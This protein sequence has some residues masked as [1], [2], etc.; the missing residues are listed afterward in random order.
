MVPIMASRSNNQLC[1]AHY[2]L[3]RAQAFR[4]P[5]EPFIFA[6]DFNSRPHGAAHSYLTTGHI[7]AKQVAPWYCSDRLEEPVVDDLVGGLGNLTIERQPT[8]QKVRYLLDATLN[9]FCRWLRILGQDTALETE[10]EERQRTGKNKMILFE[11]CRDEGRTLV[12]ASNRLLLRKDCPPGTY[13]ISPSFLA[14][15]EVVLIHML[16]THGVVLEPR[17]FLTRCVVC[18][19]AIVEVKSLPEKRRILQEYQA[20]VELLDDDMDVFECDGCRQGY[21]WCDRPTSSASRV[22]EAA[23][24]LFRL[25]LRAGVPVWGDMGAF[26]HVDVE[27]ERRIG[28]DYSLKGSELL[29]RKLEVIEWLRAERLDA[30]LRLES[31]YAAKDDNGKIIGESLPFTNVTHGFVNTLDYVWFTPSSVEVNAKLH[32]PNSFSELNPN[33]IENGHLLPSRVWP[34]DHLAIGARFNYTFREPLAPSVEAEPLLH[35]FC[36]PDSDTV[37]PMLQSRPLLHSSSCAC[38]CVPKI[39]SL[40]AMAELRKQA[41]LA[42]KSPN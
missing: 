6:G 2:I 7:N 13:C 39:P 30:P 29:E 26:D 35:D 15:L 23:T 38:G 20:P 4:R 34:S 16:L 21:W 19:G 18:N 22:M 17:T 11:R 10:E 3:L 27:E 37:L 41:K 42:G 28:W 32:V 14:S 9:K 12:T 36:A 1:Q 8:E 24:R 25:S 33:K 31:A 40:F 5:N